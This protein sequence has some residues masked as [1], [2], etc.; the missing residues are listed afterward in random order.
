MV[1]YLPKLPHYQTNV[2]RMY[3]HLYIAKEQQA[4]AMYEVNTSLMSSQGKKRIMGMKA[5]K[6]YT[7]IILSLAVSSVTTFI[8]ATKG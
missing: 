3:N 8:F 4:T 1:P 7:H 5:F 2:P 6:Q